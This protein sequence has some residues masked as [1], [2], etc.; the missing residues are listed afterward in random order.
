MSRSYIRSLL[1]SKG[2]TPSIIAK[3]FN[4][5]VQ[6]V[7]ESM[8]GKGSRRIRLEISSIIGRPPSLLFQS[9]PDKT[10]I[11]DDFEFMNQLHG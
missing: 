3:K 6:S 1:K 5:H 8:D 2:K 11:V 4:V 9:L 10:K 7:Y